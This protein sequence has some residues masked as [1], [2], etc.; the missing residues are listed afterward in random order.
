[1]AMA[2][3]QE[4][5]R[6][7]LDALL[8]L[9]AVLWMIPVAGLLVSSFRP[10]SANA[11]SGWWTAFVDPGQLTFRA[12]GNLLLN[13]GVLGALFNAVLITVPSCL[14][15]AAIAALAAYAF[16]WLRFPGREPLF[17]LVVGLLVV[18]IQVAL[19]PVAG[20]FGRLG[21]FGGIPGVVL[22][23]VA[24]GMPFAVFLPSAMMRMN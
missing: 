3:K 24:F 15:L 16:A 1:M 8:I 7:G 22:F 6:R 2:G 14:I 12:Y 11:A 19:I 10:A 23:H 21:L 18:P 5:I 4:K 9:T 20:L 17:L 13:V